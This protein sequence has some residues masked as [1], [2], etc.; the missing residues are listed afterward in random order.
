MS[1][2]SEQRKFTKMIAKLVLWAYQNGY[3]LSEGDSYRD[4]RLHGEIGEKKGY[5]HESSFHKKRLAKDLNL[6]I[7]GEYQHTTKAHQ[8]LGEKWEE[9]GGTWGGRFTDPDGNHYS[10]GESR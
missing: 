5:G 3:E 7:D 8:P 2:G 6:F 4:P 10:L 1:L 9:M